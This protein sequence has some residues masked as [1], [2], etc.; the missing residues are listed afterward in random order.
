MAQNS[1]DN[2]LRLDKWLWAARFFKT[3]S[4]A[5]KAVNGGKVHL[6]GS[7]VKAARNVAEGD[8]LTITVGVAEFHVTVLGLCQYRRPAKEARQLYVESEESIK[9]R[10]EQRETRKMF[11]AGFTAPSHKPSKRDRRKIKSFTRKD[12]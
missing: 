6:N 5:A 8:N 10:E 9:N 4:M 12:D 1:E 11:N 3:R 2:G 7:R